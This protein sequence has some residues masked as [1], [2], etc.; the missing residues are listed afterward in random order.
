[1]QPRLG[2]GQTI[3]DPVLFFFRYR[4]L[5]DHLFQKFRREPLIFLLNRNDEDA[6]HIGTARTHR[7]MVWPLR[8]IMMGTMPAS[9]DY[10][11]T[12]LP[13]LPV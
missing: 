1:M 13:V 8:E 2:P 9:E 11:R 7:K 4:D 10:H 12:E 6:S 5:P 3:D